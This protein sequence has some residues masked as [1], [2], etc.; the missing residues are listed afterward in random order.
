MK[1]K[2]KNFHNHYSTARNTRCVCKYNEWSLSELHKV[3]NRKHSFRSNTYGYLQKKLQNFG[4]STYY[5]GSQP[6]FILK[7]NDNRFY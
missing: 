2:F 6:Y 7:E 5:Y 4:Y 1:N 3:N